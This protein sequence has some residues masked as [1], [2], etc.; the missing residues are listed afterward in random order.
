VRR[1]EISPLIAVSSRVLWSLPLPEAAEAAVALGF[2]GMEIWTEH[3]WRDSPFQRVKERLA[4]FPLRYFLHGPFMDL[5][6][7]SNNPRVAQLSLAEQL[8]ALEL[9]RELGIELIVVH[10]GRCS[11]SK[12]SPKKYWLPLLEALGA[13]ESKAGKLGITVAVENMEPRPKEFMV[14]PIDFAQLFRELP[15]LKMCLDLAHA[16]AFGDETLDGFVAE[17][18]DHIRH[19]HISNLEKGRI[20]LPLDRGRLPVTP[21]VV[22]FIRGLTGAITVE[23]ALAPGLKT[24]LVGLGRL[25]ELLK[26]GD[27]GDELGSPSGNNP[28]FQGGT[29]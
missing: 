21:T 16:A 17:L 25:Q 26:G 15:G 10:P 3:L 5:N 2:Q 12:D 7:C 8:R 29:S 24:A 1:G 19:V 18:G 9:A 23:G 14:R 22:R 4:R 28:P 27:V 20:H 13:L 11:S 6:L